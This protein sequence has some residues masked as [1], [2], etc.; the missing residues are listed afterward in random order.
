MASTQRHLNVGAT[1]GRCIDVEATLYKHHKAAGF[2]IKYGVWQTINLTVSTLRR[3]CINVT[4]PLALDQLWSL[5]NHHLPEFNSCIFK[6]NKALIYIYR[7][8]FITKI[9]LYNVDPLI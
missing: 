6:V 3:R 2:S 1:S 8:Q 9:Y 4:C 5:E 7:F